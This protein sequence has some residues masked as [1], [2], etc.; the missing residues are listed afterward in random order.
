MLTN[1]LNILKNDFLNFYYIKGGEIVKNTNNE[2][3][4]IKPW[5][6]SFF[7]FYYLSG[8]FGFI[9]IFMFLLIPHF[10]DNLFFQIIET[11]IIYLMIEVLIFF[12]IP[13][14]KINCNQTIKPKET[15]PS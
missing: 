14:N 11:C 4:K 6:S 3:Y 8:I 2:C 15:I 9:I 7:K 13:L 1:K 5:I 12:V 10:F